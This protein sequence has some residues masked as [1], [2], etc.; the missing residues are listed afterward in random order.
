MQ[1]L[2]QKLK[3]KSDV[4]NWNVPI[5]DLTSFLQ[6]E[7][8]YWWEYQWLFSNPNYP[9]HS[10]FFKFILPGIFTFENVRNFNEMCLCKAKQENHVLNLWW[11]IEDL[12]KLNIGLIDS[13]VYTSIATLIIKLT[14]T[15]IRK[16]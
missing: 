13:Y 1:I 10:V 12:Q 8:T 5:F 15:K 4:I 3:R 7:T 14:K 9:G 6:Q 2:S 11:N 16:I